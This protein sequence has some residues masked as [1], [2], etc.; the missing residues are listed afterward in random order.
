MV[1]G[2][3]REHAMVR[4]L[5][6][7]PSAPELL[8]A[9]GNAGIAAD[10]HCLDVAA[11]DV[12]GIVSAAEGVDLVVVGPEEPLVRGLVDELESRGIPAFGPGA[13]AARIEGSKVHAKELMSAARVPT[14]S[15]SSLCDRNCWPE[16]NTLFDARAA[17]TTAF[18]WAG[19][20]P[21]GFSQ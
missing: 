2:G 13:E 21:I 1:G 7:S 15:A 16:V 9:P 12:A 14:A 18:T 19:V 11:D 8:C 3:G 10:A 6:R 17:S 5:A 4:A 20:T